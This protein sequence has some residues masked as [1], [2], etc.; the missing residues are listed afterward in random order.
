MRYTEQ[1]LWP[2]LRVNLFN[3]RFGLFYFPGN[4]LKNRWKFAKKWLRGEIFPLWYRQR[5]ELFSLAPQTLSQLWELMRSRAKGSD[6]MGPVLWEG[7][8]SLGARPK[9]RSPYLREVPKDSDILF[10]VQL[11]R[12]GYLI[13]LERE[14]NGTV[15][16]LCP[17]EFAVKWQ[18]PAGEVT[19]PQPGSP[20]G[21]FGADEEGWEQWLALASLESPPFPWLE[22]S[23]V[24]AVELDGVG[25]ALRH[26]T[27]L[28]GSLGICG[29]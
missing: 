29:C 13:L 9:K 7:P 10:K 5:Q 27:S 2:V 28:A 4:L 22:D 21:T 17:S 20:Y 16:C 25:E 11:E 24:E 23:K 26:A 15:C 6:K 3:R 19:L 14:P 18:L 1:A 12:S 8:A